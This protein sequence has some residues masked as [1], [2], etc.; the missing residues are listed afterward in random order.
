MFGGRN[1]FCHAVEL[2]ACPVGM[3]RLE[4]GDPAVMFAHEEDREGGQ[5]GV[6]HHPGIACNE[7]VVDDGKSLTIV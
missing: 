4:R 7:G 5:L 1:G 2:G 6:F 3:L